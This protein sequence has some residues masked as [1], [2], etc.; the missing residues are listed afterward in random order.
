MD[1][2]VASSRPVTSFIRAVALGEA[3]AGALRRSPD[4]DAAA[5]A[6]A[7]RR[8]APVDGRLV[9]VVAAAA[10]TPVYRA[11]AASPEVEALT[12]DA[13]SRL[14][15]RLVDGLVVDVQV[16]A[17]EAFGAALLLATGSDRHVEA[18]RARATRQ[19]RRLNEH[20]LWND[21]R[22]RIAGASEEEVLAELGLAYIPPELREGAGELDAAEAGR[23]PQLVEDAEL[24]CDLHV[25][26][27][28]DGQP[29]D[30]DDLVEA[31]TRRG[32]RYL[33]VIEQ[34]GGHA[35]ELDALAGHVT[36]V[37]AASSRRLRLAAGAEVAVCG[38]ACPEVPPAT[39]AMLDWVVAGV[40]PTV[41]LTPAETT[42]ALIDAIDAGVVDAIRL[43]PAADVSAVLGAARRRG[44][45]VAVEASAAHLE[46]AV[47][48]ARAARAARVPVA[49]GSGA[50]GPHQLDRLRVAVWAARRAWLEPDDVLGSLS[51]S[52][53]GRWRAQRGHGRASTSPGR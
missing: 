24:L 16:V 17:R 46:R 41:A 47:A 21:R 23:L 15:A 29:V 6:G 40:P 53:L 44:V 31:A 30:L 18:L 50:R 42:D 35:V 13:P 2:A 10:L 3:L 19:G 49:L 12:V 36:A 48:V 45:A 4:I 5:L 33:A 52:E 39:L 43:A 25:H 11:L 20:G 32:R 8:R 1:E 37:R 34:A 7:A 14:T 22:R 38:D 51:W 28:L 9:V 27:Q 26:A